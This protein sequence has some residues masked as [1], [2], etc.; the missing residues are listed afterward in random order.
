VHKLF[1]QTAPYSPRYQSTQPSPKHKDL[2]L[3]KEETYN[4]LKLP[5]YETY[6]PHD[7]ALYVKSL[8]GVKSKIST[9][10]KLSQG[11]AARQR[12]FN[13]QEDDKFKDNP[14][15]DAK[16]AQSSAMR[17]NNLYRIKVKVD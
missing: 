15:F 4:P 17:S 1:G 3:T 6:G 7:K 5:R 16:A 2:L 11:D 8:E 12:K 14:L 9:F 10:R 13:E